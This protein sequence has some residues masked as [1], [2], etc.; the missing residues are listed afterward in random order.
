MKKIILPI[1]AMTMLIAIPVFG[2]YTVQ[3]LPSATGVDIWTLLEKTVQWFF[4]IVLFIAALY[5]V[6]SGWL[7]ITAAGDDEKAKK[8]LSG[9]VHALIGIGVALL[10]KGLMYVVGTFLGKTVTF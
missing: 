9:L 6:Y 1:L 7:Y 5:I 10:A 8:A 2:A 4:N 3:D